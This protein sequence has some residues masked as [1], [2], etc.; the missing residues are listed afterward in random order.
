MREG[1]EARQ[2]LEAV[3]DLIGRKFMKRGRA[4]AVVLPLLAEKPRG[5]ILPPAKSPPSLLA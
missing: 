3:C 2:A 4:L 1:A 5:V